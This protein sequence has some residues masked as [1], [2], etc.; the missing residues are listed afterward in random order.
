MANTFFVTAE[1]LAVHLDDAD[2]QIIDAR[3][4]P[5]GQEHLRNMEAEYHISH[6]PGARFFD[7]EA[8]SDHSSPLPHMMPTAEK[9]AADMQALGISSE[10]HLVVYDE[11]N[12]FSA[13][14]AWWMLR[15][16][17]VKKVS[18][19]AGG[20]NAWKA[21]QLP[22]ESGMPAK[23]HATF[24]AQLDP[25]V[26]KNANDVLLATQND[27]VQIIDARPAARYN[28][29]VD[30]P[31]PGLRRGHIPT[32]RNVP[33][34]DLVQDGALKPNERLKAIFTDAGVNF[35]QPIIASCGSG[36]TAAVVVLA[37]TT[38]QANDVAL[39]DG[40]WSEWGARKELP[41]SR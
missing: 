19:L 21:Q 24:V 11:G 38:L 36:V 39:Y 25:L 15:S 17:G 23:N 26:V 13:P 12:L 34:G 28:S 41:V 27:S 5:A 16:F 2:I 33:W 22:L 32:S 7:I 29:E 31:R 1:W 6:L 10:K 8:L 14:R 18:I 40:S 37:L 4:A 30:E 35:E 3:M 20:F 9:F